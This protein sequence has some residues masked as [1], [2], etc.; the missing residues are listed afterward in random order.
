MQSLYAEVPP[1]GVLGKTLM[2]AL[3]NWELLVR[4]IDDPVPT[5]SNNAVLCLGFYYPQDPGKHE[6]KCT[7]ERFAA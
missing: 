6:K 7:K 2:Y 3:D 5:P 1:K 4:Y